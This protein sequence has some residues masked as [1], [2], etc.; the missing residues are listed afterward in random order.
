MAPGSRVVAVQNVRRVTPLLLPDVEFVERQ[1]DPVGGI[2]IRGQHERNFR[3]LEQVN[4]I[5]EQRVAQRA[6]DEGASAIQACLLDQCDLARRVVLA[7]VDALRQVVLRG[8]IDQFARAGH[9]EG[10][11]QRA[12]HYGD[13]AVAKLRAGGVDLGAGRDEFGKRAALPDEHV[14][15]RGQRLAAAQNGEGGRQQDEHHEQRERRSEIGRSPALAQR[16]DL[17]KQQ[18][19]TVSSGREGAVEQVFIRHAERR[20]FAVP[21][22]FRRR[23]TSARAGSCLGRA[24][25]L[26]RRSPGCPG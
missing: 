14:H 18:R 19:R 7:V 12:G 15:R 13:E 11:R 26:P 6:K 24:G 5:A 4:R 17:P 20:R 22:P 25:R 8:G 16:A 21:A 2:G 9:L 23:T 10:A 1:L 3:L